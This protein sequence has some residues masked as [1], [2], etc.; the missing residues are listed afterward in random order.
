M[1]KR[2]P[3]IE[4]TWLLAGCIVMVLI[5][6]GYHGTVWAAGGWYL[7]VPPL[8]A[9]DKTQPY[10]NGYRILAST[11][12]SQWGQE[13]AYDTA[14]TCEAI[15]NTLLRVEQRVYE[16]TSQEYVRL[17]G[18]AKTDPAVLAFQR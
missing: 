18:S 7:L 13:G 5:G 4:L 9:C 8:S 3:C 10:R 11:P 17:V 14:E 16:K 2:W 6:A 15:K 12:L 1:S